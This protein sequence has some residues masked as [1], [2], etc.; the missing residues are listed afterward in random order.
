MGHPLKGPGPIP[1]EMTLRLQGLYRE[2][3]EREIFRP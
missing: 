1:G 2:L 3:I